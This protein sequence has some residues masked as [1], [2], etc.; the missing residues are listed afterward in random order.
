MRKKGFD[1]NLV[2]ELNL[3]A[4]NEHSLYLKEDF[5]S[6][7]YSKKLKKGKFNFDMAEKGVKNLIVTPFVRDYQKKWLGGAK[8]P[9]DV[10]DALTKA[11]MRNIM[12]VI[13]EK[14]ADERRIMG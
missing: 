6:D 3:V 1:F 12:R 9:R 10:R 11:R 5:L 14:Q 7:N 2:K 4:E 8:V 13:R